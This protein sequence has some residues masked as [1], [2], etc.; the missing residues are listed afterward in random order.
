MGHDVNAGAGNE[1]DADSMRPSSTAVDEVRGIP[2]LPVSF[3][4]HVRRELRKA[5]IGR[6][7]G[8]RGADERERPGAQ[9]RREPDAGP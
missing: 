7:P 2:V 3:P 6:D 5:I 8:A 4:E 9:S 1:G